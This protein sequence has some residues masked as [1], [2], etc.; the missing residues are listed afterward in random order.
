MDLAGWYRDSIT[1]T[2]ILRLALDR[3]D[4]LAFGDEIDFLCFYVIVRD[5]LPAD[6]NA[7][8]R[9]ALIANG[10]ISIR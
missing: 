4:S 9:E 2:D 1:D 5:R 7:G 10:G 3:H 6:G 8:F